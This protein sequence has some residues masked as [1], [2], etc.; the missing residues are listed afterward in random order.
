MLAAIGEV[1]TS[2]TATASQVDRAFFR[3]KCLEK[4]RH[5]ASHADSSVLDDL[6]QH[7]MS[8]RQ[9]AYPRRQ[10]AAD[11]SI[12]PGGETRKRTHSRVIGPSP[13]GSSVPWIGCAG[14]EN[15][16]MIRITNRLSRR[17]L[18]GSSV[19]AGA[20][21]LPALSAASQD[22]A[23]T[24]VP[25]VDPDGPAGPFPIPWLDMNGSH[26]QPAGPDLEPSHIY[27]FKGRVA[28][29]SG[30]NGVGAAGNGERILFG[31]KTTDY[32]IMDGE[33]WAAREPQ[34]GTFTHI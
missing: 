1:L 29:C 5:I 25:H 23:G 15:W 10:L 2:A 8:G 11:V 19:V 17:H 3:R 12:N 32:G 28:R 34:P 22:A 24:S 31:T 33:Y 21:L 18:F 26:N 13:A 30:F 20:A 14:Q 7:R 6:L 16:T 9:L 4:S 27:H